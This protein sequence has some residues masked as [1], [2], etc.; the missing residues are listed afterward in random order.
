MVVLDHWLPPLTM[1]LIFAAAFYDA[2]EKQLNCQQHRNEEEDN[3]VEVAVGD[4]LAL[5]PKRWPNW[6]RRRR[7]F[8]RWQ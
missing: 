1:T 5:G 7:D 8:D 4:E 3:V 6:G 2:I